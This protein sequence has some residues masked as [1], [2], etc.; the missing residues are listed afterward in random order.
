RRN[1]AIL[2]QLLRG[3]KG[4]AAVVGGGIATGFVGGLIPLADSK[5]MTPAKYLLAATGVAWA[6]Q[7]FMGGDLAEATA[8]GAVA[9]ALKKAVALW[10]PNTAAMLGSYSEGPLQLHGYSAEVLEGG[11]GEDMGSYAG[12]GSY[13][14]AE[15]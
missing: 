9:T 12:V 3:L 13:S 4:G 6:A 2:G 1:P 14:Y 11:E 8:Y 10:A 7:R 5:I 15:G